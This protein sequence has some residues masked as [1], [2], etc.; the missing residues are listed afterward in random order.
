MATIETLVSPKYLDLSPQEKYD[1]IKTLRNA[2]IATVS[3]K[4]S[5][6][7]TSKTSK[8]KTQQILQSINFSDVSEVF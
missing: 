6:T 2:R 3:K 7:K 8:T 1:F 5:K 4:T